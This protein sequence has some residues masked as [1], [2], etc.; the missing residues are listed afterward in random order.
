VNEIENNRRKKIKSDSLF[1]DF[2]KAYH[3]VKLDAHEDMYLVE[4]RVESNENA[5]GQTNILA[6]TKKGEG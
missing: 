4:E 5:Q 2:S 3:R 1:I 6:R